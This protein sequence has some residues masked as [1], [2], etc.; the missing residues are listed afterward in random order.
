MEVS[1]VSMF[2]VFYRMAPFILVCFFVLGSIINSEAKGLMY[3][4]G[5]LLT[6][7]IG[8][9]IVHMVG[10]DAVPSPACENIRI[11]GFVSNV[12]MGMIIFA[13]TFFYLVFPIAKYHLELDNIP[14]LI[15]FPLLILGDIYWNMYFSCFS[16]VNILTA[17]II[18]GGLGVFWAYIIDRTQIKSLQYYNI[19][20]NRERCTKATKSKYKCT[21]YH[22]GTKVDYVINNQSTQ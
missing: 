14:T 18:G 12:P 21:T 19:G 4:A 6:T 9:G 11:S 15:F 20:S 16:M 7:V 13:Y 17:L 22:N 3:L 10:E 8:S 1:F 2:Y 5:L